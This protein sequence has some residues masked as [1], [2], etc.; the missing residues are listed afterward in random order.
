[1]DITNTA[2]SI[3]RVS[4]A[5]FTPTVALER[6]KADLR[7]RIDGLNARMVEIAEEISRTRAE[8]RLLS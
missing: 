8:L 6:R 4:E 7:R 2:V 3:P 5:F 1:M